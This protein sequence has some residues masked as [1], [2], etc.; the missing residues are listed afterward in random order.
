ME[1]FADDERHPVPSVDNLDIVAARRDGGAHL[2]II[3]S[4]PLQADERSQ[5]R[6]L[7]KLNNYV[8]FVNSDEF[9]Q[10]FGSP[11]PSK[12]TIDVKIDAG[13]DPIVF[14]LLARCEPQVR[15]HNASLTINSGSAQSPP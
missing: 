6:L 12:V 4:G 15:E 13:S 11:D 2:V 10:A 3:V 14:D 8:M 7:T 9:Q 5:R 1:M